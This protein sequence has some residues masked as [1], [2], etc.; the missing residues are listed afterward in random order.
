MILVCGEAL[1]DLFSTGGPDG[2]PC[3]QALPG[4]SPYNVAIGLARLGDSVA[5]FGGISRDPMGE[6]LIERLR[7]E[8][9]GTATVHRS[10]ALTT[11]SLVQKDAGGHPSYTFYGE[12]TADR[13]VT[14]A[15]IPENLTDLS[16][17]H[18]GSYAVLVEPVASA[19]K[20]LIR[21]QKPDCLIAFDPNIRPTVVADLDLWR[22]NTEEVAALS[23]VIKVSR[24]DLDLLY[25]SEAPE[26]AADRWLDGAAGLVVITDGANGAMAM[27]RDCRL[28]VPGVRVDVIDTVGAGDTFQAA[29]LSGLVRLGKTT[30]EALNALDERELHQLVRQCVYAS[31]ITCSRQGADMPRRIDLP[32]IAHGG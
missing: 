29:L 24:E 2:A 17:L 18:V 6:L 21:R 10:D 15:D 27:T 1:I 30:T 16:A 19:Y 25:P 5:F 28:T 23:G 32:E 4:G 20:S 14:E 12:G 31:A 9:V 13:T 3:F 22:R 11:L 7:S 26:K 8:G